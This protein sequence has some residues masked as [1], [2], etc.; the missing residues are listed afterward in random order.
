MKNFESFPQ[1][2]RVWVFALS[3]ELTDNVKT[4]LEASLTQFCDNWHSHSDPVTAGFKLIDNRFILVVADINQVSVSGCSI[5]ALTNAINQLAMKLNLKLSS[6]SSIFYLDH[7][8]QVVETTR[9]EFK[10]MAL[11]GKVNLDTLVFNPIIQDFSQVSNF[12]TAIRNS[13]HAK[14]CGLN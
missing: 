12:K 11:D 5:D 2:S 7:N 6:N 9:A 10:Q 8:Q 14:A 4:E 3:Q 13:W 1:N